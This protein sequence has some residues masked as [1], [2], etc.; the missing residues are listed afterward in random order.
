M[1]IVYT[2][3]KDNT[4]LRIYTDD[5][6]ESPRSW[7]NVCTLWAE[8]THR[9]YNFHEEQA[10]DVLARIISLHPVPEED[11]EGYNLD[12]MDKIK[13]LY[14][15]DANGTDYVIAP[16]YMYDHSGLSFSLGGFSCGWDSGIIGYMMVDKVR[17]D[18]LHGDVWDKEK[19][20]ECMA[21]EVETLDNF[22]VYGAYYY[23]VCEYTKCDC[24]GHEEED[25]LDS[26][27][28]F[29]GPIPGEWG[30]KASIKEHLDT[31]VQP[32]IEGWY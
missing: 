10:D 30:A 4:E 21:G 15:S 26:C 27:G 18:T 28:G 5:D 22:Y 2:K 11:E 17:W 24:C 19:V 23:K 16:L 1:E 7:D 12:A 8:N 3:R 32:L 14:E 13:W 6:A 29:Y 25:Q 31:N 9:Y 20:L